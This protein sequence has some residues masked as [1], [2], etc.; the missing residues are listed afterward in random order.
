MKITQKE[1]AKHIEIT[2]DM[3]DQVICDYCNKDWTDRPEKGGFVFGSY[4]ICPDCEKQELISI[5]KLNEERYITSICPDNMSFCDY[6]RGL[7]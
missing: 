5:K 4:A 7:R 2:I 6:V 1:T 3:E